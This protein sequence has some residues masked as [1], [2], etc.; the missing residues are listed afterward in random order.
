MVPAAF[1]FLDA[2]PLTS[3]G[4]LDRT[5]LP[6]PAPAQAYVAPRDPIEREIVEIWQ[7]LLKRE[8]IGIFESFFE[9]GGHS[10]LATRFLTRL[11]NLFDVKL[12]IRSFFKAP[13]VAAVAGMIEE[14]LLGEPA[15]V[16]TDN[17][18]SRCHG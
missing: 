15:A 1:V 14:R 3:N 5:A 8:K 13:T 2:L 11:Q 7:E 12:P 4:K 17:Q 9:L 10:L 6:A 16:E 18:E